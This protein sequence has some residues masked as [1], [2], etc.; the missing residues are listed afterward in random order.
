MKHSSKTVWRNIPLL[1]TEI[2]F[3]RMQRI[4]TQEMTQVQF[5]GPWTY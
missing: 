3:P 4:T 1:P 5:W 2:K